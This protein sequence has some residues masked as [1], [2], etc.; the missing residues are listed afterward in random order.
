[1]IKGLIHKGDNGFKYVYPSKY[2]KQKLT[3]L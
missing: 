1:M 3:E 2:T